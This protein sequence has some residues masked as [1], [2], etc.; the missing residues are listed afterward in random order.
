MT[1][2]SPAPL[3]GIAPES[4]TPRDVTEADVRVALS[5]SDPLIRQRGV[6]VCEALAEQNVG[7]V[8]PLLDVIAPLAGVD[9]PPIALRAI[10][11][12]D[13]VV[14]EEPNELDGRVSGLIDALDSEVVDVRLTAGT[15]LGKLVVERPELVAPYTRSLIDCLSDTEPDRTATDFSV[16]G[17]RA[18]RR[19]LQEHAEAERSRQI[20]GRQT[21]INVVV[22]ITETEPR[23]AFDSASDLGALLDDVDPIVSGG[24][25]DALAELAAVDPAVVTPLGDELIDCLDRESTIVRAR[26]IRALGHLGDAAAVPKLRTVAETASDETVRAI[27]TKTANFLAD[28]A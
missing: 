25:V 14:E 11:T 4:V 2:D 7:A 21:L 9:K 8:V 5:S 16:V 17:D 18:T 22:A 10:A 3:D 1:A 23:A 24:A 13:A 26:A 6:N 15:V 27:A 12:L 20:A 19:T 28:S